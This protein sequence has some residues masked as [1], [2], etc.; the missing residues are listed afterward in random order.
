MYNVPGRTGCNIAPPTLQRLASV[1]NIVG[2]KEASGDLSQI[3]S[4]CRDAADDFS[5]LSGDDAFTLALMAM[6]G[7]GVIS[8]VSN[9]APTEMARLVKAAQAG[10]FA[11]ARQIHER[12]LPLMQVN[13]IEANPIPVKAALA[14]MGLIE[15][16]YR[17]P[18]VPPGPESQAQILR[19]LH[20][21]GLVEDGLKRATGGR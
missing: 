1:P 11:T 17:L 2:V 14:E 9:E 7:T 5:I 15:R 8:V 10:D 20:E 18:L 16:E 3:C 21:L 6:G 4:V 12:L 19:V 13:F